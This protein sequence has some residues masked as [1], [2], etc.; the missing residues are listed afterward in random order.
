M[1]GARLNSSRLVR[2]VS[3]MTVAAV[4]SA[5]LAVVSASGARADTTAATGDESVS[6]PATWLTLTGK[7]ISQ[8][9]TA[10]GSTYR[11]VDVHQAADG[12]YTVTAVSN[13]GS[14][15]VSAW[16]WYVHQSVSFV[17]DALGSNSARLISAEQN[18]DGTYNV[19]MV[20][21]TG[22]ANRAWW[23]YVGASVSALSDRLSA[24]NA[25]MVSVQ[26]DKA[27]AGYTAIMVSNT[28]TDAKAWW[29]Y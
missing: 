26:R 13:T 28:G 3:R 7:T 18:S 6:A 1:R 17:S 14:Y 25:R 22:S 21:N 9:V 20:S 8:I 27:D 23:W 11:L 12:T 5:T 15:A 19:I 2:G 4:L 29:W 24:N 16:W 10:L